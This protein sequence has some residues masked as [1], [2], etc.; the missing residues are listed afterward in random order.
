MTQF[1]YSS[2]ARTGL[3][4]SGKDNCGRREVEEEEEEDEDEP[5]SSSELAYRSGSSSIS[6]TYGRM[7]WSKRN[8]RKEKKRKRWL[9]LGAQEEDQTG[10]RGGCGGQDTHTSSIHY[11]QGSTCEELLKFEL[12]YIYTCARL[13][14]KHSLLH[15]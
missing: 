11:C 14:R 4:R 5:T 6:Y 13:G 9:G 10:G 12:G 15:N 8:Q 2:S 1:P 3:K 7:G